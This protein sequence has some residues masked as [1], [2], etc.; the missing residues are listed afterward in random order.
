MYIQPEELE[1]TEVIV[2]TPEPVMISTAST[3]AE[4]IED[5]RKDFGYDYGYV[6]RVV[7]AEARG[8]PFECMMAVAQCIRETARRTG[9]TPEEVVKVPGQYAEPVSEDC[10]DNMEAVNEACLLV[11]S[12]GKNVVNDTIEF[13]CATGTKSKFHNSL[14]YVCTIGHTNFYSLH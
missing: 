9:K 13:F 12:E 4:A 7:G 3:E 6:V 14:R 5:V 8:E 11:L 2:E 10:D 1:E